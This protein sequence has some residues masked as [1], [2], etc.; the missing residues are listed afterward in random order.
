MLRIGVVGDVHLQWD[1]EDVR[2]LDAEA[3]DLVLITGDLGGYRA[4][5]AADV[6]QRMAQLRTRA[7]AIA[8][9][10]DAVHAA[11]LVSEAL[12]QGRPL[13]HMLARGQGARVHA[14]ERALGPVTLGGYSVHKAGPC[15][16]VVGR[17]HS[18]G[19]PELAFERQLRARYG[20]ASM[21]ASADLLCARVDETPADGTLIFLA[22]N[23]AFGH[24][25][26]RDDLC[27]RDFHRDEGDWGDRDLERA[28][29]HAQQSGRKV[30]A[31]VSGHM[32]LRLRGG[33]RRVDQLTSQGTLHLNA[34]EVPRH[35][36]A[37]KGGPVTARHHVRLTIDAE[38]QARAEHV[39]LS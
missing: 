20:V 30:A 9:N 5:G 36:R 22:H 12:P 24:G 34:A 27:G 4:R 33:G 8:G 21:E 35:R 38:G 6:G 39:W 16:L 1:D 29:L 31:V 32:H 14:L 28:V 25:Q 19:G 17:P 10:H 18:M 2:L 7:I 26:R 37:R 13:R 11:Q 23:G 15:H 3:Y